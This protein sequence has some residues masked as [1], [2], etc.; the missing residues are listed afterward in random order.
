L[1]EPPTP[2]DDHLPAT[3]TPPPDTAAP[4]P[5]R[6]LGLTAFTIEGRRA[7][8][9]FVVGWL[10]VLVGIGLLAIGSMGGA[11]LA[12]DVL[13]LAASAALSL[14]LV[15]LCGS[16]TIER[17]AAGATYAGPSP[18]LVFLAIVATSRLAGYVVGVPLLAVAD[19]V[20][21]PLG[22]LL[23]VI[24]Q[25]VV[26]LG[27]VRLTVVGPGVFS[28][29]GMGL[30]RPGGNVLRSLLGGAVFAGPVILVTSV[31]AFVAVQAAGVVPPSPLPPTGTPSGLALHLLAGAVI[32]PFYEEVMFRGFA[33][34]A[35]RRT[36][37]TRGA[38]IRSSILFVLA[39]ML[40]VGGATFDEAVRLAFVGGVV[41][42]PI[43]LALG[44]LYV[45]TG[46]LWGPIGLHAAFNGILIVIGETTLGR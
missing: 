17:R 27:V 30:E 43:A 39:H 38:I 45:R 29:S 35:W 41:R 4:A 18:V 23:A 21:R 40:F 44:W 32:A 37:G 7:P 9:L 8:A 25:A 34:N 31:I 14:G 16:Q 12:A 20:P 2:A 42:I 36:S 15:L 11:G 33:L 24:V 5:P 6:N 26:F 22:D 10:G 46:S 19:S 28:W 3:S 1:T 13:S